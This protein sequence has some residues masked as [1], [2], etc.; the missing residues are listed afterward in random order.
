ME[1]IE[2]DEQ[3][4]LQRFNDDVVIN[5]LGRALLSLLNET[6]LMI[7]NGRKL[8]DTTG[9]K[10]CYKYNGSSTVDYYIATAN[11]FGDITNMNVENQ[12]WYSDSPLSLNLKIGRE[13]NTSNTS[14]S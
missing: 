5:R 9:K 2:R 12:T 1:Y 11:L 7:V 4:L 13:L 14:K 6:K 3:E 10:T 8:G